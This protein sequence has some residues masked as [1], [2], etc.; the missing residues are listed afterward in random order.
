MVLPPC[1][2]AQAVLAG[3]A[4]EDSFLATLFSGVFPSE[5]DEDG[6][7]FIDRDP[8]LF[9]LILD[10]L[11]R[12]SMDPELEDRAR[13][14]ALLRELRFYGLPRLAAGVRGPVTLCLRGSTT[15]TIAPYFKA[16]RHHQDIPLPPEA[17]LA[18]ADIEW[19]GELDQRLVLISVNGDD[20][21]QILTY[22]PAARRWL[23]VA[24]DGTTGRSRCQVGPTFAY[25]FVKLGHQVVWDGLDAAVPWAYSCRQRSCGPVHLPVFP[26]SADTLDGTEYVA[27]ELS[28]SSRA[29]VFRYSPD[30]NTFED[31]KCPTKCRSPE[32]NFVFC[33][34]T[35]LFVILGK[36][37]QSNAEVWEYDPNAS[38]WRALP[39]IP[40]RAICDWP[41]VR[42]RADLRSIYVWVSPYALYNYPCT[43]DTGE[44]LSMGWDLY[45]GEYVYDAVREYDAPFEL[46]VSF[47]C[48]V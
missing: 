23:W 27:G 11:R 5:A 2:N 41:S 12:G 46:P 8:A 48:A 32:T 14:G 4:A 47:E 39:K 25:D 13:R 42:W 26:R 28:T 45:K 18:D 15:R 10:G 35:K 20:P 29:R 6:C 22:D 16:G 3:P 7:M 17:L 1:D 44:L 9:R 43:T 19:V 31:L 24:G 36:P 38:V 21:C 34:S 40:H 30:A 33:S 37:D